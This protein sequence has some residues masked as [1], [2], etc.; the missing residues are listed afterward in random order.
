MTILFPVGTAA[1]GPRAFGMIVGGPVA[2]LAAAGVITALPF[3]KDVFSATFVVWSFLIG[4]ANLVPFRRGAFV[5]DGRRL[6]TLLVAPAQARRWLAMI[7]LTTELY[8]GVPPESLSR[9][10]IATATADVDEPI[11]TVAAHV[12]AYLTF[13]HQHDDAAAADALEVCLSQT[14][15]T[16]E[17]IRQS[18][19]CEAAI[20]Q[21]RRRARAD[22]AKAWLDDVPLTTVIPGIRQQAEAAVLEAR[23]DKEGARRAIDAAEVS[24]RER[25]EEPTKELSLRLLR[26]W[27]NDLEG[28]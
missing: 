18:L 19:M 3:E 13:F 28:A 21:G 10:F 2:N 14:A 26:R 4:T 27:R 16:P 12:I 1:L 5:S 7:V 22:L 24:L 20:F 25:P 6:M 8:D 9:E 17:M 11:A 15:H 23:G